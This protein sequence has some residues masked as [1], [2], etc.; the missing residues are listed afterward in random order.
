[1][2]VAANSHLRHEIKRKSLLPVFI[3]EK[4]ILI[5]DNDKFICGRKL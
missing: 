4:I 5:T 3:P 1:M 2:C